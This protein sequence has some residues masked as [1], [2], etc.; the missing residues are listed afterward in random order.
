LF[1]FNVKTYVHVA[2]ILFNIRHS[3]SCRLFLNFNNKQYSTHHSQ[4]GNAQYKERIPW[5]LLLCIYTVHM[6]AQAENRIY[7]IFSR[8]RIL[9]R[10]DVVTWQL[11]IGLSLVGSLW[12]RRCHIYISTSDWRFYPMSQMRGTTPNQTQHSAYYSLSWKNVCPKML[13][14]ELCNCVILQNRPYIVYILRYIF[15]EH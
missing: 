14:I 3:D 6:I 8:W 4:K 1:V 5:F 11:I 9:L 13:V 12:L 10:S 15:N 2:M 7:V